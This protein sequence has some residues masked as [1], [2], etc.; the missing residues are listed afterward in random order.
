[1]SAGPESGVHRQGAYLDEGHGLDVTHGPAQLYDTHIRLVGPAV[2]RLVRHALDPVLPGSH[3]GA[4]DIS[5]DICHVTQ[6][7]AALG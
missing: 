6:S 4:H 5:A 3:I 2:H 1:M 7:I